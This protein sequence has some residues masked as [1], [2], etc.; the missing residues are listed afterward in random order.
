MKNNL[1]VIVNFFNYIK[2]EN[3]NKI[4]YLFLFSLL[5]SILE[6]F[7]IALLIPIIAIVTDKSELFIN[8]F[9]F[10]NVNLENFPKEQLIIFLLILFVVF[11]FL[12]S[13]ILSYITWYRVKNSFSLGVKFSHDLFK[14]YLKIPYKDY[15]QKN[16]SEII[17]NIQSEAPKAFQN[18]L[19][20][21]ITIFVEAII[22]IGILII[23]FFIEPVGLVFSGCLLLVI[24]LTYLKVT[25]NKLIFW[26]TERLKDDAKAIKFIQQGIHGLREVRIFRIEDWILNSFF[27][28]SK[29]N[30]DFLSKSNFVHLV[31]R[32]WFEFIIIIIMSFVISYYFT[33]KELSISEVSFILGVFLVSILKLLPSFNKISLSIQQIVSQTP[34]LELIMREL[35][36]LKNN[37]FKLFQKTILKKI[38]LKKS[39]KI[40]NL[41]F[42]YKKNNEDKII[43]KDASFQ[44]E[45]GS[46]FG[47]F[48]KSGSGKSTIIDILAGI[49]IPNKGKVL[50]DGENISKNS[51]SWYSQIGYVP[52]ST[53]LFDD[54]IKNNIIFGNKKKEIDNRFLDEIIQKTQLKNLVNSLPDKENTI[55]GERGQR[56]SG[57]ERQRIGIARALFKEPQILIFDESTASLDAETEKKIIE[58]IDNISKELTI[59]LVSHKAE[60]IRNC[61]KVIKLESGEIIFSGNPS[62]LKLEN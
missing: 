31:S 22:L 26:G 29:R 45:K 52:Q 49:H 2:D 1:R 55:I 56:I 30:A 16:S 20:S 8:F 32:F 44:I 17:R 7:G 4:L 61:D 53:Y 11:S 48:G 14:E 41:A 60:L 9:Y 34:G 40:E 42:H 24:T 21:I 38:E 54:T 6:L 18:I 59:I 28:H 12:K 23:L 13:L 19:L 57:G 51:L 47:I 43:I 27:K 62:D 37:N 10:L 5:G 15:L 58:I 3:K 39:I 36:N 46:K 33:I 25:R 50:V 35:R